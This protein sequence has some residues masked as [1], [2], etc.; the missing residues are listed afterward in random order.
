MS[1]YRFSKSTLQV[2]CSKL[3]HMAA[4]SETD[5]RAVG[6]RVLLL[7]KAKGWEQTQ[8][9]AAIG[10]GM[11]PQRLNNY[12]QGRHGLPAWVA[13]RICTVTGADFDYLYRDKMDRLPDSL[14]DALIEASK[15]LNGVSRPKRRAR[16]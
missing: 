15:E 3:P 6:R 13:A 1:S 12:V 5:N 16:R 7:C 14:A 9:A 8:L 2:S 4:A 11:T 10:S